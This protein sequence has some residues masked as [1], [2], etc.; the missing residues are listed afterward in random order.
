MKE[1]F[2][3]IG[4]IVVGLYCL[5]RKKRKLDKAVS[6]IQP[7]EQL[8]P[9]QKLIRELLLGLPLLWL[10]FVMTKSPAILVIGIGIVVA[11]IFRFFKKK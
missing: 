1:V 10:I 6:F 7:Q 3:V 9:H 8:S 5:A 2:I 4:V 11:D